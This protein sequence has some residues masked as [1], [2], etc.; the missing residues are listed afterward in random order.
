MSSPLAFRIDDEL[1]QRLDQLSSATDRPLSYLATEAL[2]Q[3]LDANEW[4]VQ[5][6]AEG[7][8]AAAEGRLIDHEMLIKTWEDKRA[9][10]MD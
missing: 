2:R 5:A 4:Q 8:Q 6:I 1:R 3:Y 7:L 10:A 9:A